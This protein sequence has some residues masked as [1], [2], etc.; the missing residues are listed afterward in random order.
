MNG[1]PHLTTKLPRATR[2]RSSSVVVEIEVVC[3]IIG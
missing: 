3:C 1:L 2:S